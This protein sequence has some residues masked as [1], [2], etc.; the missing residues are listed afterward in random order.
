MTAITF[1][2][3]RNRT[4]ELQKQIAALQSEAAEQIKPLLQQ[5]I[6][7][8]PQVE[9][10]RWH[11]YTPYFNDGDECTFR[12]GDAQFKFP[13]DD[14]GG[15]YEDGFYEAFPNDLSDDG[16]LR[17]RR[18]ESRGEPRFYQ[19]GPS[20]ELCSLET[21]RVCEA[22]ANELSGLEDALKTL[23]GDHVKVTVTKS[24]V[25]VEEYDHG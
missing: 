3:I 10:V 12:L 2:S 20:L 22:L 8:N 17:G 1:E 23:F 25:N 24:G 13:G 11:Q 6:T 18:Y 21:G 4:Q 16:T 19:S 9:A 7:D 15:D 5:F 14:E